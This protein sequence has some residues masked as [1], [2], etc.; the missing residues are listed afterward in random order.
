MAKSVRLKEISFA[1]CTGFATHVQLELMEF[2]S[3][4][5]CVRAFT[6]PLRQGK[7]DKFH[8]AAT[9]VFE[10]NVQPIVATQPG[11]I[12]PLGQPLSVQVS[13]G[14]FIVSASLEF[15]G[16]L[17]RRTV[18]KELTATSQESK[19]CDQ[20]IPRSKIPIATSAERPRAPYAPGKVLEVPFNFFNYHDIDGGGGAAKKIEVVIVGSLEE[21]P[22]DT[23]NFGPYDVKD[24]GTFKLPEMDLSDVQSVRFSL[25]RSNN[26]PYGNPILQNASQGLFIKSATGWTTNTADSPV[27]HGA[28]VQA[29]SLTLVADDP[30]I[31]PEADGGVIP[32]SVPRS[33]NPRDARPRGKVGPRPEKKDVR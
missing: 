27:N 23:H 11:E 17:I 18:V 20:L 25:K 22:S 24:D 19:Y 13:P 14:Q 5:V 31:A 7:Y 3:K 2:V 12:V 4:K 30:E 8:P 26:Q 33:S 29:H 32:A 28:C 9:N 6:L 16:Q 21:A 15:R 10:L 1:D